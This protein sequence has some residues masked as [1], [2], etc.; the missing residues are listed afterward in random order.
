MLYFEFIGLSAYQI[1]IIDSSQNRTFRIKSMSWIELFTKIILNN[2]KY[3]NEILPLSFKNTNKSR[4][5][6]QTRS[7]IKNLVFLEYK[8]ATNYIA[9]MH[10]TMLTV[11]GWNWRRKTIYTNKMKKKKISSRKC[12]LNYEKDKETVH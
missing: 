1:H 9:Y 10:E 11:N 8:L 3:R 5:K 6:K 4:W 7:H 2:R 12:K